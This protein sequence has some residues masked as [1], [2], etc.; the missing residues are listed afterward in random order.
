MRLIVTR[1]EEDAGGVAQALR[2]RGHEVLLAPLIKIIP[3]P[4][5]A[6]PD[7]PFQAVCLTSANAA[8]HLPQSV[9]RKASA[10]TPGAQSAAAAMRAGFGHVE[11]KGGNMQGLAAHVVACLDPDKGPILY[12]AGSETS[13]DLAGLLRE[14]GF[15]VVKVVAYDAVPQKLPFT[16]AELASAQGVLL[17]S[18]RTA[19]IWAQE[20]ARL[21]F[22][23]RATHFCLS[24]QISR[25]LPEKWRLR[26]ATEPSE[27]A[28]LALIDLAAK[29]A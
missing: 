25:S 15:Q 20:M 18:A 27:A 14:A 8:R 7:L 29:S 23:P 6:V 21:E 19:K 5:V 10:F 16:V 28:L 4:D 1:P 24:A 12:I 13:G 26:V 9:S 3:R 2:Q 22:F 17:Y 11:A